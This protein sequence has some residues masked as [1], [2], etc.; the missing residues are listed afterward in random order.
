MAPAEFEA[1]LEKV[2]AHYAPGVIPLHWLAEYL[3][4]KRQAV[5]YWLNGQVAVPLYVVRVLE[6][7]TGRIQ[8]ERALLKART[9]EQAPDL[10]QIERW[11]RALRERTYLDARALILHL[12]E[13]L[14]AFPAE[15][16]RSPVP[17]LSDPDP[18]SP[19]LAP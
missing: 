13:L 12:D 5:R 10:A 18:P 14:E 15:L 3:G 8:L 19:H 6:G 17:S 4:R 2:A 9:L 11:V 1:L 16:K 7:L